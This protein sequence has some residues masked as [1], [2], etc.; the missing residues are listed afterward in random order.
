MCLITHKKINSR[1]AEDAQP[2]HPLQKMSTPV[3]H[4]LTFLQIHVPEWEVMLLSRAKKLF[5]FFFLFALV[6]FEH[7]ALFPHSL[8]FT[9]SFEIIHL[10]CVR[11]WHSKR[12]RMTTQR[13]GIGGG[14]G[15]EVAPVFKALS[16]PCASQLSGCPWR[17]DPLR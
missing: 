6:S 13:T 12:D 7:L 2:K 8:E 4:S 9:V 14:G 1:Y 3:H 16:H 5:F 10:C 11:L 15:L 17:P